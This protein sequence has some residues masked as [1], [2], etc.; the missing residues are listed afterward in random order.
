MDLNEYLVQ[1]DL[2]LPRGGMLHIENG[3]DLLV[4]VWEGSLWLTQERDQRDIVLQAGEWFRLDRQG[5]CVLEATRPSAIAL[6]SPHEHACAE[7]IELLPA[8]SAPGLLPHRPQRRIAARAAM[9]R[10]F[11]NAAFSS[12]FTP[13]PKRGSTPAS[14]SS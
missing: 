14:M 4:H 6:T 11:V 9:L 3:R 5:S 2:R 13:V 10:E 7:T 8:N 12:I 1:G